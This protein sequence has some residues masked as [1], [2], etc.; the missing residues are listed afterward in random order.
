M[1]FFS[2]GMLGAGSE[3]YDRLIHRLAQRADGDA[4]IHEIDSS[5][6][7]DHYL[8]AP[9]RHGVVVA[10]RAP[11]LSLAR[12][13]ETAKPGPV[14]VWRDPRDCLVDLIRNHAITFDQALRSVAFSCAALARFVSLPG[15]LRVRAR[16]DRA[17]DPAVAIAIARHLG[18]RHDRAEI[19][20]IARATSTSVGAPASDSKHLLPSR[21]LSDPDQPA[22]T[23]EV[24]RDSAL[25]EQESIIATKCLGAYT[26][27]FEEGSLGRIYWPRHVFL[28]GDD[29]R[30][31]PVQPVDITGWFRGLIFG[32]Y[33]F[34]PAGRWNGKVPIAVAQ[35]ALEESFVV[36]VV[37][38]E[39]DVL[40]EAV[41]EPD[42]AGIY[43]VSLDFE[44]DSAGATVEFRVL[45]RRACFEGHIALGDVELTP[46]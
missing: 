17:I 31:A 19:V 24:R 27:L 44:I 40:D 10:S 8:S 4:K 25:S 9:A 29:L 26:T 1:L 12:L 46:A 36:L 42:A 7:I 28:L 43:R 21:Y 5:E 45:N 14:L 35:D 3:V 34:L 13:I 37:V 20:E 23:I 15:V 22:A 2:L 18:V 16:D 38:N 6:E 11:S 32:P 33:L 41:V 30:R 39:K